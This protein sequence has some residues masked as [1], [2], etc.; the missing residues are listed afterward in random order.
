MAESPRSKQKAGSGAFVYLAILLSFCAGG[1]LATLLR[2]GA[3]HR[4]FAPAEVEDSE[5]AAKFQKYL[6]KK[7][8]PPHA[9][10]SGSFCA[11]ALVW[12]GGDSDE[13]LA[14]KILH[15]S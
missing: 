12:N 14:S 2:P 13:S 15:I 9:T 1:L 10:D 11:S 8:H 4:A 3:L 6:L 5:N 7:Q